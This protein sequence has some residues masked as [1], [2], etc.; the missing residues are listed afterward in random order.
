MVGDM[1]QELANQYHFNHE[2]NERCH[3]LENDLRKKSKKLTA[4]E[5]Q[6]KNYL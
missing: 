1:G 6:F 3:L 5:T 2:I 4:L